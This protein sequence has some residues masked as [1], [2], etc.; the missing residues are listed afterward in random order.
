M[1]LTFRDKT[2]GADD[3]CDCSPLVLPAD[4]RLF[5]SL[6]RPLAAPAAVAA[7]VALA[8]PPMSSLPRTSTRGTVIG[9]WLDCACGCA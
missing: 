3:D 2:L 4:P 9:D 8:I 7:I 5:T 1:L 6:R